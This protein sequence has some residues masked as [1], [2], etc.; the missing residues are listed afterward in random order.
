MST[1]VEYIPLSRALHN[2]MQSYHHHHILI[3]THSSRTVYHRSCA[4][5]Y[6]Y[7]AERVECAT[8]YL[9]IIFMNMMIVHMFHCASTSTASSAELVCRSD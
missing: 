2:A 6:T 5:V 1:N 9:Y 4:L 7:I 3:E 8:T